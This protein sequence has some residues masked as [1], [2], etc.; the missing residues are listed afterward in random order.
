MSGVRGLGHSIP[1]LS[2]DFFRLGPVG[3][4]SP[5]TKTLTLSTTT[6][7]KASS[8]AIRHV[9]YFSSHLCGRP[10]SAAAYAHSTRFLPALLLSSPASSFSSSRRT[11][12]RTFPKAPPTTDPPPSSKQGLIRN[13]AIQD[14][15]VT[16]IDAEGKKVGVV[17]LEKAIHRAKKQRMDL[18]EMVPSKT[19]RD[20]KHV[21]PICK[22]MDALSHQPNAP[23]RKSTGL[24]SS[25]SA[26]SSSA[27]PKMKEI[28]FSNVIQE[29]D[30]QVKMDKVFNFLL[31]GHPV[32]LTVFF[33][34]VRDFDAELGEAILSNLMERIG[35]YVTGP[36]SPAPIYS[37]KSLFHV[38]QPKRN[39]AEIVQRQR[40]EEERQEEEERQRLEREK[41]EMKME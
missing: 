8:S 13:W 27:T 10:S 28:R 39:I 6:T 26:S 33:N 14:N 9:S 30:V 3:V 40:R 18:V 25:S 1:S 16:L 38:V 5:A 11:Y 17:P 34:N 37:A 4:V 2:R 36:S 19:D 23:L 24:S 29:H 31:K 32:K 15:E 22:I 12:A 7:T 35:E 21:P 20:G 41:E